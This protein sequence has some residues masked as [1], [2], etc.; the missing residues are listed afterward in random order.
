MSKKKSFSTYVILQTLPHV[1]TPVLLHRDIFYVSVTQRLREQ[2]MR[3][4]KLRGSISIISP[5]TTP[6]EC[7]TIDHH[8][9]H[10]PYRRI[11][12]ERLI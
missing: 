3:K 7:W 4:K 8:L 5:K 6:L 9:N 11:C 10:R 1:S 12:S 2:L